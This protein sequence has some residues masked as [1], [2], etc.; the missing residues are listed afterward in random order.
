MNSKNR[1]PMDDTTREA[2][3]GKPHTNQQR[4]CYAIET[5]VGE[6]HDLFPE[7][8]VEYSGRDG[9]GTALDVSFD[10][11]VLDDR[12]TSLLLALLGLLDSDERVAAVI[13]EDKASLVSMRSDPRTQD[14]RASFGT[15][16]A[17]DVLTDEPDFDQA[18]T[19]CGF[20]LDEGGSW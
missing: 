2:K 18:G 11:S 17:F 7:T 12:D 14:S 16:D 8:P 15:A 1:E 5:L 6:V 19:F 10:L 3:V 20:F 13:T 9:R 4:V